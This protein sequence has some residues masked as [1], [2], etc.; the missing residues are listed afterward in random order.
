MS[1]LV[2]ISSIIIILTAI[3]NIAKWCYTRPKFIVNYKYRLDSSGL[4]AKYPDEGFSIS[5]KNNGYKADD[6]NVV[7]DFPIEIGNIEAICFGKVVVEKLQDKIR[8]QLPDYFGTLLNSD[9]KSINFR[10][11]SPSVGKYEIKILIRSSYI[12][13]VKKEMHILVYQADRY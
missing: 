2:T 10:V 12:F 3:Y 9:E 1:T 11:K 5:I 13:P 8:I 6:V 4:R 7:F